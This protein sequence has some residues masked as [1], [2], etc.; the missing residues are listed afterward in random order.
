MYRRITCICETFDR[1]SDK[2]W[3]VF[4]KTWLGP[5]R[6]GVRFDFVMDPFQAEHLV[7]LAVESIVAA[8]IG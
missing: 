1:V 6:N 2:S 3:P 7:S 5:I 4:G 8:H